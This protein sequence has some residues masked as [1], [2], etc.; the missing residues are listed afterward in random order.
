MPSQ[1]RCEKGEK[2]IYVAQCP[3][4]GEDVFDGDNY[5]LCGR[6]MKQDEFK[7]V[8]IANITSETYGHPADQERKEWWADEFR[9]K[10][11]KRLHIAEHDGS[12][13]SGLGVQV[14]G[15]WGKLENFIRRVELKAREEERGNQATLHARE[16]E[17][18]QKT[19]LCREDVDGGVCECCLANFDRFEDTR[20]AQ[21]ARRN[22]EK[23]SA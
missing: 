14:D 19:I 6:E 7:P 12:T 13:Y 10:F 16:V 1:E 22:K 2:I 23:E 9:E 18:L 11:V 3:K 15:E 8:E 4:C 20:A 17:E 21:V 5:C